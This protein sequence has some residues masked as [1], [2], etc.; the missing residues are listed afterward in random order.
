MLA[1]TTEMKVGLSPGQDFSRA[2]TFLRGLDTVYLGHL[3]IHQN[4]I[5]VL[6][7]VHLHGLDTVFC[8]EAS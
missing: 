5:R 1:V 3:Q 2:R 4:A 6:A 7:L 8:G